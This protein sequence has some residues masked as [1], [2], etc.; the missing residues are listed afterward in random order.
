MRNKASRR[1]SYVNHDSCESKFI[2]KDFNKTDSFHTNFS[3]VFFQ[4][5]SFVSAKMKFCSFYGAVF[6]S[7]FV[8]GSLFRGCNFTNVIF[9]NSIISTAVFEKCVLNGCVFENCSVINSPVLKKHL[10]ENPSSGAKVFD[11][12]PDET[13]FNAKLILVVE[14]LRSNDFIRRSGVLHRKKGKIDTVSLT[15]LVETFGESFLIDNFDSIRISITNQFHTLSYISRL[16][17]KVSDCGKN[18]AP[19]PAALGAPKLT[20]ECSSTD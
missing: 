18:E 10:V 9:K 2:N 8:K 16:L 13:K 14:G 17:Y 7:C 4:N 15:V 3:G 12:F 11:E 6:E 20:N 5:T 1:Y 19:G